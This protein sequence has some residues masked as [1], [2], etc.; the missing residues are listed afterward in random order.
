ME[1]DL[2]AV[3]QF[4]KLEESLLTSAPGHAV[5]A[6]DGPEGGA[7]GRAWFVL[8][9]QENTEGAICTEGLIVVEEGRDAYKRIGYWL[10]QTDKKGSDAARLTI[11]WLRPG[12]EK[13]TVTLV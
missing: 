1:S 3:V 9:Y 11:P 8:I 10:Y 13:R 6:F 2:Q 12:V 5:L 4:T 7:P